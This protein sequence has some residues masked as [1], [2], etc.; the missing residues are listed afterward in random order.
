[1]FGGKLERRL[2]ELVTKVTELE[3]QLAATR[4]RLEALEAEIERADDGVQ[5]A[6][7][8]K[9]SNGEVDVTLG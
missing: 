4:E 7:T 1:M 2:D 8:L 3:T 9:T 5:S 6:V